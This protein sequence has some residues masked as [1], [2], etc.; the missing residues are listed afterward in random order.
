MIDHIEWQTE[1]LGIGR[2]SLFDAAE[3]G[4]RPTSSI[5]RVKCAHIKPKGYI[6]TWSSRETTTATTTTTTTTWQSLRISADRFSLVLLCFII[7]V[8][9]IL[10]HNGAQIC[11]AI[12]VLRNVHYQ[13]P[14]TLICIHFYLKNTLWLFNIAMENGP[15]I[16][17]LPIRNGDFP[18]LC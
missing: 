15:F 3:E 8:G 11:H 1:C 16:D 14:R 9:V 7:F 6:V 12:L 4:N 18:W 2:G 17:G 5:L 13:C 10:F